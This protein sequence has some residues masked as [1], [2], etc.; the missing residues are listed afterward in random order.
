MW[1]WNR[2]QLIMEWASFG[3]LCVTSSIFVQYWCC[4]VAV[5]FVSHLSFMFVQLLMISCFDVHCSYIL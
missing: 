2:Q 5:Y 3:L 1:Q 4:P